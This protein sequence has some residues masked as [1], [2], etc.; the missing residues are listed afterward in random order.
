MELEADYMNL[1]EITTV[2][3]KEPQIVNL[4]DFEEGNLCTRKIST[5]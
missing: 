5:N 3:K 1:T 2:I 4:E